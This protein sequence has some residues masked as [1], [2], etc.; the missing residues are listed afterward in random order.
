MAQLYTNNAYGVLAS[1]IGPSDTTIT[2]MSGDGARFPNPGGGDFFLLTLIA[3]D[4]NASE[5]SWEI[6]RVT[7]R[8]SDT[9]TVVRGQEGTTGLIWPAASRAELRATAG[10][11][12]QFA[13]SSDVQTALNLKANLASPALTGTPTA[14][15]ASVGTNTTQ[16]A[17]TAYVRGEV[18]A[19]VASA[20][21]ALDTLNELATALGNDPNFATTVTNSLAGKAPLT[22]AG[23]SGTWGI[24]I[25]GNA[26]TATLLGSYDNRSISPSEQ[27]A[28]R[29]GFG[30][31]SWNN[32]DSSP[33]ADFLHLRSYTDSSGGN[34]NLVMFRKD[35]I[36]MRIWQQGWGSASAYSSYADVLHSGNYNSYA[37]PLTGGTLTGAL[38][39]PN[40]R[41]AA[42]E[43]NVSLGSGATAG[44]GA[45]AGYS[46]G[47]Y[48]GIGFNL[49]HTATSEQY[50]AVTGDTVSYLRFDGGGFR[51]FGSAAGAAGRTV[52]FTGAGNANLDASGNWYT[53][54]QMYATGSQHLVLN[55]GNYNSYAL[56]ITGGTLSGTLRINTSGTGSASSHV[57]ITRSGAAEPASFGSYSGSWRSG[58]EI[59]NTDSASMLF[60][61]PPDPSSSAYANIKSVGGGFFI[62]VGS[63]GA[64]RAIQIESN[65]TANF[66]QGVS[67]AG[68]AV[69][70]TGNY[71][72]YALPLSGGTMTGGLNVGTA[73][74][75]RA[76]SLSVS[77]STNSSAIAAKSSDY[78]TVFGVLPHSGSYTYFSTGVYYQ[79]GSWVHASSNDNS[80]L[81][82]ISGNLGAQWWA[83]SNSS[84]SWNLA[85]GASLW[86]VSGTWIGALNAASGAQVNGSNIWHA[87]NFTPGNYL[88]LSGGTLS[89]AIRAPQITAGGS[90]NTDANFGVQGTSHL[91]GTVYWGGTVGN[92][93]SWS[94]LQSSSGGNHTLSVNTFVVNRSGYGGISGT[95]PGEILRVNEYG[96]AIAGGRFLADSW[97][98]SDRDFPNGTLITTD[99]NYAVTNGDPFILEIRGN[100]YGNIIPV[101]IQYQGYIYSDTIINHGGMSN[102]LNIGGLVAINNGG[103]L[104]FWFPSQGYWNG[105]YVRVYVPF[106]T[107]PRNRVTS[108]TGVGKPT[109]AKQVELSSNIRQAVHSTNG[110]VRLNGGNSS[111][112]STFFSH[113][114]TAL[115]GSTRVVNFDGNGNVPSVWWTNGSRAYAAIDATDPGLAFWANNGSN[116]QQQIAMGYGTVNV[117]TTLQQGGNQVLHAGNF[118][119]YVPYSYPSWPGSPGT[120]ANSFHSGNWVRSSFTYSNNAPHTGTIVHFPASGY[121]LQLNGTYGGQQLS[122]RSRNGDNG[123]WNTWRGVLHDGNYSSYALPLSG[124]TLTGTRPIQLSTNDGALFIT[125]NSGGWSMGTYFKGSAGTIRAGFG[126]YGSAD[127]LTYAWI[128]TGYEAA[129]M[130][131]SPSAIESRARTIVS[132]TGRGTAYTQSSLELYTSDASTPGISFHRNGVS[133]T[134]LYE[135]D[136]ELYVNAWTTRAQTGKLLSSGNYSSYALP[137]SGGTVSGNVYLSANGQGV[138]G[139]S[140]LRVNGDITAAR[141]NGGAGVIYL[142][143]SG[144]TYVYYDGSNYYMPGGQLYVNGSIALNGGNYSSYALPL[145]GGTLTGGLTA[146][147]VYTNG[148]W[149]RNHTNNNG[150]YWSQTGWHLYPADSG[151]FYVRSGTSAGSLLFLNSGGSGLGYVHA[152]ADAAMGF[153]TTGGSWRFRVDNSGNARSYNNFYIDQDYGHGIVGLYSSYRYQGVF[154]M[155]D[156][157]KLPADG[158]TTGNLYGM[159]WS[160]P[161]AGGIAGNLSSHGLL[162]LQNGG[163]MCALSTSIVA[164][165]NVT[166][167]SD[168]RLKTNWR[169]MP[170]NFVERL[171]QVKVG[172]YDRI[173]CEQ[174]TQVGIGAQSFQRLLPE[175]ITKAKDEIG[176]LSVSYGNAAMASAVEL[177]K[178]IVAIKRELEALKARLH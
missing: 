42:G 128:G 162:L 89:G 43:F 116:W 11:F 143:N 76:T 149:F 170:E 30:F 142:G 127:S 134:L 7:A 136:G 70:T 110:S 91:T 84:A 29:F 106:A 93:N 36:G 71:N 13:S 34:D 125:G 177:A 139:A 21:G 59:W 18:A 152:A 5:A 119:S 90:N 85:S 19:L 100:S 25:T 140:T 49:R 75:S 51:F 23:T 159:A 64:T 135:S 113:T 9:L 161:N 165:G 169:P 83:S 153:L 103:N 132:V 45:A 35:A 126:A 28:S 124:G 154:A 69:L 146:P 121:D 72:S 10:T 38:T 31:T 97:V 6:V 122:F 40:F 145:S 174:I 147:D 92:V 94:S 4:G 2:L 82:S 27:T 32:N 77:G 68:A 167:F 24:S 141:G 80:A 58:L 104:C 109:T 144:S 166:A 112:A 118:T 171:A 3:L 56:P 47:A 129:W 176:T 101:D 8:S 164:S 66:P 15:T 17:T 130:T 133:A 54:G 148:G 138:N 98:Q 67:S 160:H 156:S 1:S 108:I 73:I 53:A 131:L 62:D 155:G 88:A 78:A 105:Y 74:G 22:G 115:S 157:Y 60:L 172:I 57:R 96:Y 20:P 33:Y 55:T 95:Y 12:A 120:D 87:G 37:L 52:T 44:R 111:P 168:E 61:N 158:T 173:D 175:A 117:L 65:G 150:V 16:I 39:A 50:I 41:D 14:P 63:G 102:G 99:I 178:E 26:T 137:L 123:T 48:G 86:N 163:F 46:G 114:I 107:Y 81:F 151:N 79:S